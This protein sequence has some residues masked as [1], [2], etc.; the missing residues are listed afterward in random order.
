MM[1]LIKLREEVNKRLLAQKKA[2]E[3]QATA[4]QIAGA[5]AQEQEAQA[6][7]AAEVKEIDLPYAPLQSVTSVKYIDTGGVE[8]TFSDGSYTVYTYSSHPGEVGL[9][10]DEEWPQTRR[11]EDAVIVQFKAGY[12]DAG[13]DVPK[14]I[15]QAMLMLISHWYEN[16]ESTVVGTIATQVP[17]AADMLLMPYRILKV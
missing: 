11:I 2:E 10:Y 15:L 9:N 12:G 3:E 1:H 16:R 5:Q 7:Q 8:Q 14:P 4:S 6:I 17:Q 13:S